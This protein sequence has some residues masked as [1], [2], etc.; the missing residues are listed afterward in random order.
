M[1]N[2]NLVRVGQS[3]VVAAD[4]DVRGNV[5]DGVR[6]ALDALKRLDEVFAEYSMEDADFDKLAV[7]QE[8]LEGII[9][10]WDAHIRHRHRHGSLGD[11]PHGQ[12]GDPGGVAV[13][14]DATGEI[15]FN[16]TAKPRRRKAAA[17]GPLNVCPPTVFVV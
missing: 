2:G 17:Y 15:R 9:Q 12:P 8:K 13:P 16:W 5:E 3:L 11:A 6:E 1:I 7:E 10:A 4:E 14:A